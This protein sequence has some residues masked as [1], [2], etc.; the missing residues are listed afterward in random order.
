[1]AIQLTQTT[2]LAAVDRTSNTIRVASTTN[3][4]VANG[5]GTATYLMINNEFMWV[6]KQPV[7]GGLQVDVVRGMGGTR[8]NQHANGSTVLIGRPNQFY[9]VDP[10]GAVTIANIDVLPRINVP[11]SN[12]WLAPVDR[13]IPGN[14][15][16]GNSGSPLPTQASA[17]V[18]S[19][20]GAIVPSGPLF[21]V[22]GTAAV[23][24]FTLP[25]GF[26]GGGF[27]IIPDGA[28]TWT[29]AGNIAVAGTAT[30]NRLLFFTY[31]TTTGKFYPSYIA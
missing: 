3:I 10:S 2:L 5:G 30:V 8:A 14:G 9:F 13:W 25:E 21:H 6:T 19:A 1:M 11:T 24:G 23:T 12:Q 27:A 7:V 31:D 17:A 4:T 18:A 28:F 26:N 15:N 29:T 16:P 20:A 22:T